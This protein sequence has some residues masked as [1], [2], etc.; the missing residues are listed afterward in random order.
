MRSPEL[1][2]LVGAAHCGKT[3]VAILLSREHRYVRLRFADT[4]KDM[5]RVL[6]LSDEQLD[7]NLKEVPTDLLYG[8]TPRWAMQSLGTEW[9]AS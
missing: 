3:T 7:G 2:G 1:I 9:G 6:G 5:L 4:I 8:K